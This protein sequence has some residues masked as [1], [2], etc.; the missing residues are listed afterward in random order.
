MPSAVFFQVAMRKYFIVREKPENSVQKIA[1]CENLSQT[2][3][4]L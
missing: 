2:V 4:F 3:N 1:V